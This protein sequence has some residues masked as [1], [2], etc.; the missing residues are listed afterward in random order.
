MPP[1]FKGERVSPFLRNVPGCLAPDFLRAAIGL[2][3]VVGGPQ[4]IICLK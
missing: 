2:I 1:P 3:P 4:Y